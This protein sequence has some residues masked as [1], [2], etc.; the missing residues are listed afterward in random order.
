MA[1]R[2]WES[3]IRTFTDE[4]T[5]RTIKQLTAVGNN[6]HMYFTENSFVRGTNANNTIGS[7][8]QGTLTNTFAFT[9]NNT[10]KWTITGTSNHTGSYPRIE[11]HVKDGYV[12]EVKGGGTYGELWREFL[13]Y[14]KINEL[15]YP[16]QDKQ[17]YWWFYEAGLG[18]NPKFFK[19]PDENMDREQFVRA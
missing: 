6:V 4:T 16:Y 13:K 19:R 8:T 7:I 3:E 11:V 14:P 18:T 2:T 12:T 1:G 15:N 17:G 9:K 5:G 10:S